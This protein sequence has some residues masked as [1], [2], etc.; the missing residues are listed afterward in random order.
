M[1][2]GK[3]IPVGTGFRARLEAARQREAL[4]E[5]AAREAEETIESLDSVL[6]A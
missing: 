3:L 5:A 6:D 2:I 4:Q 1:I